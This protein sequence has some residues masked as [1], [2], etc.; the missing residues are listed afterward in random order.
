MDLGLVQAIRSNP[1]TDQSADIENVTGEDD[2]NYVVHPLVKRY[3]REI[4]ERSHDRQETQEFGLHGLLSRGPFSSPGRS[5][6]ARRLFDHFATCAFDNVEKFIIEDKVTD[7]E[8]KITGFYIRAMIDILRSNFAC[9]SVPVWGKFRDY[10]DMLSITI[11]L[12][13]NLAVATGESWKPGKKESWTSE[14]GVASAEEMLYLYNELGLAYYNTGSVQDALSVWGLA[15]DWQKAVEVNDIGQGEMYAASLNSHLGMAY[16]QLGRMQTAAQ[17]FERALAGA[18]TTQN[19]DL[20]LR[21][22]G[23]LGRVAHFRGN[24]GEAR[25]VYKRVI[26]KLS[27]L[28]NRRAQSYFMRHLAALE[29]RL[30][31]F[32]EAK[33]LARESKAIAASQ[34]AADL[35]AFA[36][37]LEGRIH[38]AAGED[39]KAI[40]EYR[41]ALNEARTLDIS[42]LQ[43]D[44]L[45]GMANIQLRLGDA[46]AAR[47][48]AIEVLKLANENLLV[49]RQVK[50]LVILGKAAAEFGDIDMARQ[51]LRHAKK[52]AADSQFRL[53]EHDAEEALADLRV[54]GHEQAESII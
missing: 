17:C 53:V 6:K 30:A 43:A 7:G 26:K 49:L 37:E 2:L 13:R 9:N 39:K 3:F 15:F 46:S 25:A 16:L 34:N 11:D 10:I 45:L 33:R 47:N 42:R 29:T 36:S 41:I 52:L 27:K 12:L 38:S 23:M 22:E 54:G 18:K 32:P 31:N 5:K 44:I 8:L 19:P 28:G 14:S 21:M 35:V 4:L 40:R 51:T 48:R 20:E 50:A 24:L 1:R